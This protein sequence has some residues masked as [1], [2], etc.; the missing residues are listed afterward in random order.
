MSTTA[1]AKLPP[2]L[3]HAKLGATA[4]LRA[5]SPAPISADDSMSAIDR[6][7]E[8]APVHDHAPFDDQVDPLGVPNVDQRIGRQQHQVGQL[9]FLHRSQVALLPQED[10]GIERRNPDDRGR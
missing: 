7:V 9:P 2:V 3:T 10:R 5:V 1:I 4:D 8:G 6:K